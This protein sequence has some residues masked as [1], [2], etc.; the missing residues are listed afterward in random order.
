MTSRVTGACVGY[1]WYLH[2]GYDRGQRDNVQELRPA[3]LPG[4]CQYMP[5]IL[6]IYWLIERELFDWMTGLFIDWLSGLYVDW[7]SGFLLIDSAGCILIDWAGCLLI[8]WVGCIDWLIDW[9]GCIDSLNGLF[10]DIL[11]GVYWLI[12]QD[13]LLSVY[14]GTL[15]ILQALLQGNQRIKNFF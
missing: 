4:T 7:L 13:Y 10:I 15:H 1:D 5:D 6:K 12:D 2:I 14:R 8:Y 11:S 9:A 3:R